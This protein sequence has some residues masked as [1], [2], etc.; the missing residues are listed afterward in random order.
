MWFLLGE[1]F[2]NVAKQMAHCKKKKKLN[3]QNICDL[4]CTTT[5]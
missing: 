3:H 5:N 4:G 1:G 2:C